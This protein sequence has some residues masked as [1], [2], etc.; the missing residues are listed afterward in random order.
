[1]SFWHVLAAKAVFWKSNKDIV[2]GRIASMS[3][4]DFKGITGSIPMASKIPLE[5]KRRIAGAAVREMSGSTI[6]QLLRS[7]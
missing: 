6:K 5:E 4:A 3:D 1:V 7:L 2:L